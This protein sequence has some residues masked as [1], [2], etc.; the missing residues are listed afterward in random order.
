MALLE[1]PPT[2]GTRAAALERIR[3]AVQDL[4]PA[5]RRVAEAVL[6][7]PGRAIASSISEFA[8]LCGVAQPTVSRFCRSV[9]FD[10]YVALRLGVTADFATDNREPGD[11]EAN[12]I[13]G[14]VEGL[15]ADAV[16]FDAAQALR[17]ANRVEIW[18]SP[19]FASAGEYL[20]TQLASLDVVASNTVVP[21]QCATRV[22]AAPVG[23][24][25]VLLGAGGEAQVWKP[26]LDA[27]RATEA[28]VVYISDRPDGRLLKQTDSFIP[29]PGTVPLE[30]A[31]PLLAQTLADMV[32]AASGYAGPQGPASPWRP[33]PHT[34]KVFLVTS[35]EPIPAILLVQPRPSKRPS[36]V[37]FYARLG[38]RKEELAP[39]CP[40]IDRVSACIVAALLNA[41]HNVL[42]ADAPGHGER[43]RAWE[44]VEELF[45]AGIEEKGPD[46]LA[47]VRT[48]TPELVDAALRLGV[49]SS[50]AQVAVVGQSAGGM[51]ALLKLAGD[52][53]IG[54][55]VAIMPICD[56][57]LLSDFAQLRRRP[58]LIAGGPSPAMGKDLAPRPLLLIGG[59]ADAT[60]PAA[61]IQKFMEGIRPAYVAARAADHL[62]YLH[63]DD[64]AHKFDARQVDA[65]LGWL[66]KHL[67]H[68]PI[69]IGKRSRRRP[70][71]A[72]TVS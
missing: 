26:A 59:G 54:C 11:G 19:V 35:Q 5:E 42:L 18:S 32:R 58:R 1:R 25:V 31:G 20:A 4:A 69:A 64:V 41:G 28:Q 60:A 67:G 38:A 72:A 44:D 33:W 34:R 45:R 43:K 16:A 57:T 47:E 61:H 37:L 51:Q 66:D 52:R 2:R 24:V 70:A 12:A 55:G 29:L 30:T 56:V 63:L 9:G 17:R 15:R 68:D 71:A 7:D 8:A 14:L 65:T 13:V 39:P 62:E 10:S 6:A 40:P 50:P 23:T 36:L 48:E 3:A 53:R 49:V 27:S 22:E 21:S 46:Y